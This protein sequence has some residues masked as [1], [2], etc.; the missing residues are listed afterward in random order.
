[1]SLNNKFWWFV[2][3]SLFITIAIFV[4]AFVLF[5][6]EITPAQKA[7]LIQ[8][9]KEYFTYIFG[10]GILLLAGLGFALD[11]VFHNYIIPIAKL[12]EEAT[13]ITSV[14]P[15]HRVKVDGSKDVVLLG[16]LLNELAD[17]HEF[18]KTN[19]QAEVAQAKAEA[20]E[21]KDIL[22]QIMA[23]LP[24]GVVI[25]NTQGRV[26]LYNRRAKKFFGVEPEENGGEFTQR[27]IGLGRSIFDVVD[28]H[29]IVHALNELSVKLDQKETN[30]LSSFV[31][32]DKTGQ[33]IRVEASPVLNQQNEFAGFIL[34]CF[35]ITRQLSADTRLE[36]FIQTLT[37]NMRS[38]LAA[39]R[40]AIETSIE[41]PDI[42]DSDLLKLR[43]II[44]KESISLSDILNTATAEYPGHLQ[45]QWPL[46]P[47]AAREFAETLVQRAEEKLDISIGLSERELASWIELDVYSLSLAMLFLLYNLRHHCDA[48]TFSLTMDQDTRYLNV[49][50]VWQGHP[51]RVE[52]LRNWE[53]Q[54][55]S[56]G[57]ESMPLTLK[58]VLAHHNAEICS[59]FEPQTKT[60]YVRL[61]LP[62]VEPREQQSARGLTIRH[63]SRPEFYDFD[64]FNR[65]GPS[66]AQD[67]T[68]L[69]ELRYTVFDTETTGLDPGGGD[70]II[71]IGA[72]R[73]VNGRL[74]QTEI[75]DRLVNPERSLPQESIAVHGVRPE[76]LEGKPTIKVVL[77]MFKR[78]VGNTILVAHN[79]AFDMR[80][81]EMEQDATGVEFKNPVLD[82]LLLSAVVNPAQKD[83][84]MEAIA[85][86][87]GISIIGRHTA[88]GDAVT[89]GEIFLKLISLLNETGIR[90]LKQARA[91]SKKSYYSRLKY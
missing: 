91:A 4:G 74:L 16:Q 81:L 38:P 60:A 10:A 2:A 24:E 36:S 77:P 21:E 7:L 87:L 11:G 41:F 51:V 89:T 40:T 27:F 48:D 49:D 30:P 61:L 73:I 39:I 37:K 15:S 67:H 17:Q 5:W 18:L 83:H 44:Y 66:R 1:M 84:N 65:P 70:K 52:Q 19:V 56:V 25:C 76:M 26:L 64:L 28:K 46:T 31:L 79:A 88:I 42:G 23:E 12:T 80:M 82:T 20:E 45:T 8:L 33:L 14:N 3:V 29:L 62:P 6:L 47:I 69:N 9:F 75:F 57:E 22:S 85:Q 35:D 55:L 58:E 13:L 53:A 43:D 63:Q 50:I 86:R 34:I 78:F 59:Y 71:S 68:P 72:I 32:A 54:I 90:T